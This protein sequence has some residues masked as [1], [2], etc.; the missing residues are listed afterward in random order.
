MEKFKK[1]TID[2][3]AKFVKTRGRYLSIRENRHFLID[4]Y[5]VDDFFVELWYSPNSVGINQIR[6][7]KDI[8]LL[9]PYLKNI[10]ISG[11]RIFN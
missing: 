5:C 2:Q 3:Q 8:K 1:L 6:S 7:F 10:D 4:L 9:E 11:I